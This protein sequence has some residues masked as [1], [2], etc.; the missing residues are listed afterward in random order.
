MNNDIAAS[1]AQPPIAV[2][3]SLQSYP[4]GRAECPLIAMGAFVPAAGEKADD[5]SNLIVWR[6]IS[7]LLA[8]FSH[9]AYDTSRR[10]SHV[11][12]TDYYRGPR[13]RHGL[14]CWLPQVDDSNS[15]IS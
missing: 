13:R 10:K 7:P 3:F 4:R 2:Q 15:A 8:R 5:C 6:P 1:S 9:R 12:C 14:R 11:A